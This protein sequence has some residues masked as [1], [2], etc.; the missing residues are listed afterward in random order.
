MKRNKGNKNIY[1]T[2]NRAK[3]AIAILIAMD[4]LKIR[5]ITITVMMQRRVE[6]KALKAVR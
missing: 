3:T 5:T 2:K 1:R 6:S 4:M